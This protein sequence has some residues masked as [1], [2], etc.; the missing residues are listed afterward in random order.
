MHVQTSSRYHTRCSSGLSAGK[1]HSFSSCIEIAYHEMQILCMDHEGDLTLTHVSAGCTSTCVSASSLW[2][3]AVLHPRMV[4]VAL[5]F[6]EGNV[7]YH[8]VEV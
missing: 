6:S 2:P 8:I 5:G 1:Y 3:V 4:T 7:I